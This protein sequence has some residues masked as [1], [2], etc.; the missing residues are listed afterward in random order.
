[1]KKKLV[2][3]RAAAT[4]GA[5]ALTAGLLVVPTVALA[6]APSPMPTPN[7]PQLQ[8]DEPFETVT[9]DAATGL[10][11]YTGSQG[12]TY[13]ADPIWL[14]QAACNGLIV[15]STSAFTATQ[16]EGSGDPRG[17]VRTLA[18]SLG[19]AT[20]HAV[21]AYTHEGHPATHGTLL[22]QSENSGITTQANRFYVS[23]IDVAEVNCKIGAVQS[24]IQF[25][26][27]GANG[28]IVMDPNPYRVCDGAT[29]DT[30]VTATLTSN[31]WMPEADQV[32]SA[33]Y[34]ARNLA[35]SGMGNDFAYD[36]LK[37]YDATPSLYKWFDADEVEVGVA[38]KMTFLVVNTSELSAKSGWSFSD[39]LPAGMVVADKPNFESD[40]TVTQT[41]AAGATKIGFADGAI[42][43]GVASCK[44]SL[45]V[46]LN[47]GGS[48]TNVIDGAVGL[49]GE[50]SAT[51]KALVPSMKLTKTASPDPITPNTKTVDYTFVLENDGEVALSDAS[52]TDPGPV[53]GKGTMSAL[54]QADGSACEVASLAI[55][56]TL[57]CVAT[58]TLNPADHTGK[59]L[60][61]KATADATTPGGKSL[62]ADA[63]ADVATVMPAPKLD[64]VKS[65]A[66]GPATTVGQT[67]T[68]SFK[69]TNSGNVNVEN[70]KVAEG[71]FSGKGT[72]SPVVCP[73]DKA[74]LLEVGD[75]VTCAATYKVVAADL[76]GKD[77]ENTATASGETPFGPVK[78][79]PAAAKV[80]TVVPA[81]LP[82]T[83]GQSMMLAGGVALLLLAVGATSVVA[84][85]RKA[86][87]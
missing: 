64:L 8:F 74:K 66:G 84:A 61:N 26:L 40:C 82:V 4:G 70:I 34:I 31:A 5:L 12:A 59:P 49:T 48:F 83:G 16:C 68:Y 52:I 62:T 50:P 85:R 9:G 51:I 60:E 47:K 37:F 30:P 56:D 43:R 15:N 24:K 21:T 6:A 33:Q 3:L 81:A 69:V 35:Q 71:A 78:S 41:V 72:L 79:S 63:V 75:S 27:M 57:K 87:I 54:K 1:M 67:I 53:G 28:E 19:G 10:G 17:N 55:G 14:N 23:S 76:I 13:T 45:D 18:N 77:I 7:A 20:N 39:D 80:P 46:V 11:D 22:V 42:G 25:G 86:L 65:A 38:T 36:N 32:G 73:A 29:G 58:Y 2:L 44:I